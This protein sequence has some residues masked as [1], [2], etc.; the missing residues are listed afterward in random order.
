MR[1]EPEK[2]GYLKDKGKDSELSRKQAEN[3]ANAASWKHKD[4]V[5]WRITHLEGT[6][7][8]VPGRGM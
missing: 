3:Q 5:L 6:V 1:R 2:R 7:S 8:D 4:C